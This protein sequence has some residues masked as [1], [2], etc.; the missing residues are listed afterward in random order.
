V[1]AGCGDAAAEF[2]L[3]LVRSIEA[4]KGAVGE[5]SVV[6]SELEPAKL[7]PAAPWPVAGSASAG[8]DAGI[9]AACGAP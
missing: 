9:A 2:T 6:G 3:A 4:V 8:A 1:G 5:G 7:K